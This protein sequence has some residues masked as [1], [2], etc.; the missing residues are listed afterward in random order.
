[1]KIMSR[2]S[3]LTRNI[4]PTVANNSSAK[5]SPVCSVKVESIETHAVN[6]VKTSTP[7]FTNCVRGS[8]TSRP[9]RKP[10]AVSCWT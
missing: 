7:C 1:M 5:Y 2:F 6:S 10:G 4:I 9:L 8:T 3:A